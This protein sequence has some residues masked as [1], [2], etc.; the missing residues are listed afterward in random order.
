[1]KPIVRLMTAEDIESVYE[2]ELKSF[3]TPWTLEA[4]NKEIHENELSV[5]HVLELNESVIGYG[6]M[7]KIVD[8]LHVTNFAVL[9][10]YRG[11]G[12]AHLLMDAMEDYGVI[13]GFK[14]MTLEVRRSN[15]V[16]IALYEKHGFV[17]AGYRPQYYVDSGEDALVMWREL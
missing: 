12:Y 17:G 5:Y 1:M 11:K 6:G 15:A 16:A 9:P 10:D 13:H 2:I 3:E 4:F 14:Y 7:W 8:E